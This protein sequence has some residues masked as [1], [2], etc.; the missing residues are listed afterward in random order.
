MKLRKRYFL[1]I[2]IAI[3]PFYKFVHPENYC[4]GDTDLVIIGGF[5]VLFAITFLVIFFNNLYLITIKRELFNYRPVL[6][7]VVFLIALYTTLGLH[8]QNIFKDQVKVYKGFSKEKD[9][10]EINLYDDNT[11]ELK[12]IYDKSYCVE[13]GA[14]SFKSDT[15]LLN[16]YNKVKGNIIFDDMYI[17]NNTYKSLNPIYSSLPA[18]VLKK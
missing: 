18:F 11:F 10:L 12:I 17:Y 7:A 3:A 14:Y 1:L 6:I 4:F 8:D 13:K 2:F 15:L 16:K 5:M 9:V